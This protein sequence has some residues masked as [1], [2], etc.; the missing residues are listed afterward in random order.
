[1]Q[2]TTLWPISQISILGKNKNKKNRTR[3]AAV[4]RFAEKEGFEPPV[5]A[6]GQRFSRPPHS[7]TLPFLRWRKNITYFG[8]C[9]SRLKILF[10]ETLKVLYSGE[11]RRFI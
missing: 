8:K 2:V 11:I 4:L 7:T 6:N 9:L 10:Y 3:G 5:R 1:M